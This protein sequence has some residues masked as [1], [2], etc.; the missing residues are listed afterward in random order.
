MS[1]V[2]NVYCLLKLPTETTLLYSYFELII[3]FKLCSFS[4]LLLYPLLSTA[5]L[6]SLLSLLYYSLYSTTLLSTLSTLLLHKASHILTHYYLL[7]IYWLTICWLT[8]TTL[9]TTTLLL[10]T[11]FLG[12]SNYFELNTFFILLSLL[13]LYS[14]F[15]TY[16]IS[17][18]L[19]GGWWPQ[20][21]DGRRT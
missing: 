2:L 4:L 17:L 14:L 19:L 1:T 16:C 9:T 3:F 20:I 15:S 11:W 13:L 8:P 21:W 12:C 6:F 10:S 18:S 5:S 7:V